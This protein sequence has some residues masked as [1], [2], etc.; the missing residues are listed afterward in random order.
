LTPT[1]KRNL[2]DPHQTPLPLRQHKKRARRSAGPLFRSA[3][4]WLFILTLL[5]LLAATGFRRYLDQARRAE[6]WRKVGSCK[7]VG[8]SPTV[9]CTGVTL[10][11]ITLPPSLNVCRA[12]NPCEANVNVQAA[13]AFTTALQ[14]VVAMGLSAHITQFGTVNRRRCKDAITGGYIANCISKHSYGIAVDTRNFTDNANWDAVVAQEPEVLE[15]IKIF[16][17]NGFAWGGDF[18]S[19]FDPQHLEWEPGRS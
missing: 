9:N 17:R 10:T 14:E 19:N 18:G 6:A 7:A 3:L 12:L 2:V 11:T 15:V 16:Q 4:F 13:P 5:A 1:C 8:D